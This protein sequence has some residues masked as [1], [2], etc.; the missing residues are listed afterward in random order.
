MVTGGVLADGKG[1]RGDAL[2]AAH[3]GHARRSDGLTEAPGDAGG[4][5]TGKSGRGTGRRSDLRRGGNR[6]VGGE[7]R[8]HHHHRQSIMS[9][10]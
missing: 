5:R 2:I 7:R 3:R 9:P 6:A 10:P 4:K 1:W 8:R